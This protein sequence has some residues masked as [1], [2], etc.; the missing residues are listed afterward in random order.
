MRAAALAAGR[1]G[2]ASAANEA[3]ANAVGVQGAFEEFARWPLGELWLGLLAWGLGG[4]ANIYYGAAL[5]ARDLASADV[6]YINSWSI[7]F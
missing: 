5:R 7:T 4:F 3:R 2:P 1:P 6:G